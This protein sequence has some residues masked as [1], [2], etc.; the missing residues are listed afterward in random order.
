MGRL[1]VARAIEVEGFWKQQSGTTME[2]TMR[3]SAVA[4]ALFNAWAL[5]FSADGAL[6]ASNLCQH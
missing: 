6:S 4:W 1:G 5:R 2:F 3:S